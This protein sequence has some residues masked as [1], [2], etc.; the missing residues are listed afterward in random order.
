MFDRQIEIVRK[1]GTERN[2][3]GDLV[4]GE[5]HVATCWAERT[6]HGGRENLYAS[7]IVVANEVVYTIRHRP[8]I[9]ASMWVRDGAELLPIVSIQEEGRKYRL[10]LKTRRDDAQS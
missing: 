10:H 5:E 9:N 1:D 3:Y 4:G 8:G 7:R 2:D 6:E